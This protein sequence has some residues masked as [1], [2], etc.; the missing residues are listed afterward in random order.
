M[1]GRQAALAGALVASLPGGC[2][3]PTLDP[4]RRCRGPPPH[5]VMYLKVKDGFRLISWYAA[6]ASSRGYGSPD[7]SYL[8]RPRRTKV[9][10]GLPSASSTNARDFEFMQPLLLAFLLHLKL[11]LRLSTLPFGSLSSRLPQL[12][13][14]CRALSS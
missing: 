5:A 8:S 3:S 12:L 4:G 9:Y 14:L 6:R 7:D 10:P 11:P 2:S 13:S 1:G